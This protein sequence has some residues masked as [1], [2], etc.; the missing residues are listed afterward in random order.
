[1]ASN[2]SPDSTRNPSTDGLGEPPARKR[3]CVIG[4]ERTTLRRQAACQ[5]CRLRKVKCDK[6]KPCCSVCKSSGSTCEYPEKGAE[7]LTLELATRTLLEKLDQLRE[8]ISDLKGTVHGGD[9][10]EGQAQAGR[11]G[12]PMPRSVQ[13]ESNTATTLPC[14]ESSGD[15]LQIP[16]CKMSADTVLTWEIFGGKYSRD[17]LIGVLFQSKKANSSSSTQRNSKMVSADEAAPTSGLQPPDDER[18]P[19]LIDNFLQNVHTKNPILDVESLVQ[20]GR[21]CA[22]HGIGWDGLSCLV[23]LACALGAL[24][25]PFDCPS[26]A[27]QSALP[28]ASVNSSPGSRSTHVYAQNLQQADAYFTLACRRLGSLKHTLLG[29]Q[30]YFF[31]GVY[32]MY[33]LRPVLSWQYFFHASVLFNLHLKATYGVEESLVGALGV[34]SQQLSAADRKIRRLEHSLYWS[35][36][37]SECEFRVEL[38]LPQSELS[39]GE[40]PSLFPSPPSPNATDGPRSAAS[41]PPNRGSIG[42]GDMALDPFD[43]DPSMGEEE[44]ELRQ[45]ARRLCNEEESWYYYLTEIALRRI[46]NRIINTF[47]R[48]DPASWLDI[49]PLLRIG[50]EFEAQVL[51]WSAHLPPAMQRYETTSL[52]RAPHLSSRD[53]CAGSHVSR[54]LSWAVDNRLVEMQTWLYQPFL[55]Y[56]IHIGVYPRTSMQ[57]GYATYRSAVPEQSTR[58]GHINSLL[59]PA[60]TTRRPMAA[61]HEFN[62]PSNQFDACEASLDNEELTVLRALIASGVQ[63]NLRTLDVRSVGHRHHGLWYDLRSI[64][65][66][67]LI[68]LAVVKS[69]NAAWIPGG[70]ETLWGP[71]PGGTHVSGSLVPIGGKIGKVLAQFD[72]WAGEAPDL[73]RHKEI[74]EQVVR[75][76]RGA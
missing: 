41:Q 52:I 76:V 31:A 36:F 16:P 50:Q 53:G 54:E 39:H 12:P 58:D 47:F 68:L 64:M 2:S 10:D 27:Q 55:Y 6:Q 35:C 51:S 67:S 70:A 19:F 29:A 43:V 37:K 38:P 3:R 23:L 21:K 42:S 5:S 45:H 15:F 74:L 59:N 71:D 33:A 69:G 73:L 24:A 57:D 62:F 1:M 34:P 72:F 18:I 75:E 44:W 17:T 22:A 28:C 13:K 48:Q 4:D 9:S 60:F 20:H 8:E 40:Y 11:L 7:N 32:L 56:L 66:A 30:C 25:K 49:K 14:L 61:S 65:C 63:C 46:G 26:A